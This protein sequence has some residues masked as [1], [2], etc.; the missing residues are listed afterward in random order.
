MI[1]LIVTLVLRRLGELCT[2]IS[3]SE[4]P[5]YISLGNLSILRTS[6]LRQ[7]KTSSFFKRLITENENVKSM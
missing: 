4:I 6:S 1:C 3:Q 5:V 2:F 7:L